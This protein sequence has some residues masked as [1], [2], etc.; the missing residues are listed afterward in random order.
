[1]SSDDY[2]PAASIFARA[3]AEDPSL[4][5]PQGGKAR[6]QWQDPNV[7]KRLAQLLAAKLPG[8]LEAMAPAVT[9]AI[10]Q[11]TEPLQTRIS[12]QDEE[13]RGLREKLVATEINSRA[14]SVLENVKAI[15]SGDGLREI[16]GVCSSFKTDRIGDKV[17][18]RGAIVPPHVPLLYQHNHDAICGSVTH[19]EPNDTS[20]RFKAKIAR[21]DE[22]G[23]AAVRDLTD[24]VWTMCREGMIRGVSIGFMPVKGGSEP[25]PGGV[26]YSRYHLLEISVVSI[27]ANMDCNISVIRSLDDPA[28]AFVLEAIEELREENM[29]LR[30]RVAAAEI[31]KGTDVMWQAEFADLRRRVENAE[32]AAKSLNHLDDELRLKIAQLSRIP[33]WCGVWKEGTFAPGSLVTYQGAVWH[34]KEATDKK[35]GDGGDSGWT[36]MVKSARNGASA[37]DI[38]RTKGGFKGD[39]REWL[40]SLRGPEGK[41]GPMGPP[42]RDRT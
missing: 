7:D 27:P 12:A 31:H 4:F 36:L 1:M 10:Q 23:S 22:N 26:L 13:I 6:T 32:V 38:A 11:Q 25:I 21:I 33:N 3:L 15:E 42:G 34:A 20:I 40:R 8:L 9:D 35:P 39:E 19:I 37:F 14:Y 24:R 5:E 29:K 2:A 30:H 41:P 18:P 17:D 28:A 16:E